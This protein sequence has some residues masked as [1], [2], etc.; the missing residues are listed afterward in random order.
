[1]PNTVG[2]AVLLSTDDEGD[3]EHDMVAGTLVSID[4]TGDDAVTASREVMTT[5]AL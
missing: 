1:M 3:N 2:K 4:L 5:H